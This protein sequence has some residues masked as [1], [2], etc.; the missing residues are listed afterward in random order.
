MQGAHNV[1]GYTDMRPTDGKHDRYRLRAD[2]TPGEVAYVL[3]ELA[4]HSRIAS[5][6]IV[7]DE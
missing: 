6:T 2:L 7:G 3:E 4:K 5:A 1:P